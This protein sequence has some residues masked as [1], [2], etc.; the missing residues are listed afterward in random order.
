MIEK[1]YNPKGQPT[2]FQIKELL[3]LAFKDK[4]FKDEDIPEA[5]KKHFKEIN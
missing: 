5:A 3:K 2:L 4:K 1:E